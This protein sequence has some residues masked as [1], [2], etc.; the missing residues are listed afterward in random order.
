MSNSQSNSW[1]PTEIFG[2]FVRT[3]PIFEDLR[4]GIHKIIGSL[5]PAT[6]LESTVNWREVILTTS[7]KFTIRGLHI[8]ESSNEG[9]KISCAI[10]GKVNDIT[11]DLRKNSPTFLSYQKIDLKN[12]NIQVI[13]PPGVAHGVEFLEDGTLLYATELTSHSA[14]EISINPFSVNIWETPISKAILSNKDTNSP[15]YENL[16]N[17]FW[18]L[19]NFISEK[20]KG[21][22]N[23]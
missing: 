12:K 16:D 9:W 2:C 17:K 15:K 8:P 6:E 23:G 11:L 3:L 14:N 10:D 1:A 22:S 20:I 4:G 5:E 18:D 21:L 7:K 13:I 19:N